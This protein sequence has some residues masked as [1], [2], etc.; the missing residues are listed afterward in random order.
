MIKSLL[1][2]SNKNVSFS[3]IDEA[4][5][6]LR[7]DIGSDLL[8]LVDKIILELEYE[9]VIIHAYD[10]FN[11]ETQQI[12]Q[13]IATDDLIVLEEKLYTNDYVSSAFERAR[14]KGWEINIKFL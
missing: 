8:E 2:L 6:R 7:N 10:N 12:T 9:G 13:V 4:M 1:L 3:N 11:K 14:S 5:L